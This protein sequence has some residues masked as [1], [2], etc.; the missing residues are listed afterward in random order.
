MV[1]RAL[2]KGVIR[3]GLVSVPVKLYTA[4]RSRDIHFRQLHDQD[5]APVQYRMVCPVDGEEVPQQHRVKGYEI[6]KGEYVLIEPEQ[7]EKLQPEASR[8]IRVED[9]VADGEIDPLYFDNAYYL[10]PDTTSAGLDKKSYPLLVQALAETQRVAIA[11]FVMR[12]REYIGAIRVT[13]GVLCMETMHYHDEVLDGADYGV[14]I[15]NVKHTAGEMKMAEQLVQ[16]LS[17]KKFDADKYK[18]EYTE[19]VMELIRKKA[20]GEKIDLPAPKEPAPTGEEAN[21]TRILKASVQRLHGRGAP[22]HRPHRTPH[23][24]RSRAKRGHSSSKK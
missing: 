7:L 12:K 9:V 20:A 8:E 17:S 6:R 10:G 5:L 23:H 22:A 18:D 21:L 24:H 15:R 19:K 14:K 13:D 3:L 11:R 4:T 2:W 1:A 16:A